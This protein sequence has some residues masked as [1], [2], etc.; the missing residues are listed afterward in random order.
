MIPMGIVSRREDNH[1]GGCKKELHIGYNHSKREDIGR[2][3][4]GKGVRGNLYKPRVN[5]N[6]EEKGKNRNGR[7]MRRQRQRPVIK[8]DLK[9]TALLRRE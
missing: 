4:G 9:K 7:T 2:G 1:W 6:P 8:D 5:Q 3:E